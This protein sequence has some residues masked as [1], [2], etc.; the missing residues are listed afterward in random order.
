M[1]SKDQEFAEVISIKPATEFRR[2]PT[3]KLRQ[4]R[5][6]PAQAYVSPLPPPSEGPAAESFQR[7][8]PKAPGH[9]EEI[10]ADVYTQPVPPPQVRVESKDEPLPKPSRSG[11][12]QAVVDA[13]EMPKVKPFTRPLRVLHVTNV[14][15]SNYYLNSLCDF[16]DRRAITYLAVTLGKE[17]SFT[18][19]LDK[20]G[21]QVYALDCRHRSQYPKALYRLLQIIQKERI[22]IVHTHLVDP[23]LVGL[24]AAK[25]R[26]RGLVVT[27]HHSDAVYQIPSKFKRDVY[28]KLEDWINRQADHIIAP[29]QMVRDIL[30]RR[31]HVPESK[32]SLIPYGQTLERF[33]TVKPELVEKLRAELGMRERLS[34][35]CVARLHWEKGHRF[36][37]EAFALL[38]DEGLDATLYLVGIGPDRELLE[39][40]AKE[41]DVYDRVVFLG[42]RDDALLLM[43]AADVI[44]HASLQEALPS[45]VIEALM[46]ERP[47]VVTDVSGVRDVVG[48]SKHGIIVPPRNTEALHA[49]L[50]WTVHNMGQAQERARAGRKFILDYMSAERVAREYFNVYRQVMKTHLQKILAQQGKISADT[51][52]I[53]D[54][55]E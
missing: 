24:L 3:G 15:T 22:D 34:L 2:E 7:S 48:N 44:V 28:L 55:A 27:R 52:Q 23:T 33:E 38:R 35:L 51:R 19:D 45:V 26:Q 47:L 32:V 5:P 46:L 53:L 1:N 36:L 13:Y 16:T 50:G 11:K 39:N 41:L 25:Q 9:R 14:E 6:Q 31:E 54:E 18:K 30:T 21:V 42:W 29:S 10:L 37:L 17:G 12:L 49:A 43:A 4:P 8:A 20:R 40:L